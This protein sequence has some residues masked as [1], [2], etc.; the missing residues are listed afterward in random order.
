MAKNKFI[1]MFDSMLLQTLKRDSF[2][3]HW[4]KNDFLV[5]SEILK[6]PTISSQTMMATTLIV[7]H[8]L[9]GIY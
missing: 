6:I 9:A 7:H 3:I 1:L 5:N 8:N 2:F 4:V